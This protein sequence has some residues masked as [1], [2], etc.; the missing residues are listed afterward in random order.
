MRGGWGMDPEQKGA[1]ILALSFRMG[2]SCLAMFEMSSSAIVKGFGRLS[3][4]E[5][6]RKEGEEEEEKI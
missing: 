6:R 1:P 5:G 3:E 4:G 2:G